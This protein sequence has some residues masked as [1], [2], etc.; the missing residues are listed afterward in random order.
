MPPHL[1]RLPLKRLMLRY[2]GVSPAGVASRMPRGARADRKCSL[3]QTFP[4]VLPS[5]YRVPGL[6]GVVSS[7]P[8]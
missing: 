6:K 4:N 3:S 1:C 5:L 8:Y 7:F 2:S